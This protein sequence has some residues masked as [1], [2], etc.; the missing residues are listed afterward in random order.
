METS[1]SHDLTTFL[2]FNNQA[3]EAAR[4]YVS[5][6]DRGEIKNVSIAGMEDQKL[7][8][9]SLRGSDFIALD[10]GPVFEFSAATSFMIHCDSQEEIDHYWEKLG[11]QGT[12]SQCGWLTDRFGVTWQ[13]VPT[14]LGQLLGEPSKARKV[15][16][17]F[18]KMS[19]FVI[20]DLIEA[21]Q[22]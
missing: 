18:M 17:A 4:Y 12:Y 10:G 16:E 3:E 8:H 14:I 21:A 11:A 6:F 13:V 19:K 2:W 7:V 1:T 9:F 20:A 15:T 5:V 22:A